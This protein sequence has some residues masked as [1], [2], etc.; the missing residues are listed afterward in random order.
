MA[1]LPDPA[2]AY[3]A[4]KN[5]ARA[6]LMKFTLNKGVYA[7]RATPTFDAADMAKVISLADEIITS[8][9]YALND[10]FFDNFAPDNDVKSTENIYHLI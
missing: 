1:S 4:N 9:K 5:A 8:N 3:V 2:P 6:L 10:N 7:N